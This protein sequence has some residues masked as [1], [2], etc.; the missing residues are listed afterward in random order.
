[1]SKT[2]SHR[3]GVR[4]ERLLALL[5]LLA[6]FVAGNP[7]DGRAQGRSHHLEIGGMVGRLSGLSVK[8]AGSGPTARSY[9][10]HL[11]FNASGYASLSGHVLRERPLKDSPLVT[12]L[13]PGL[14][15][16]LDDSEVFLGPSAEL[17]V[18]FALSRYR[19]FLQLVPQLHLV[20]ELRGD[21]LAAAGLRLTF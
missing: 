21:V 19:A 6:A 4:R 18:F 5:V 7:S 17:G 14:N 15:L 10:A 9:D 11:S 2:T 12:F 20:P 13:G 3:S 1:M 8:V 16:G